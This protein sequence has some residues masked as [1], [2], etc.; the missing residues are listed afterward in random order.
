MSPGAANLLRTC[1]AAPP[2]ARLML[3]HEPPGVGYYDDHAPRMTAEAARA[4]GYEV[5]LRE[6]PPGLDDA[7]LEAF[8]ASLTGAD[9][10]LFFARVGDQLRFAPAGATPATMVYALDAAALDG[11]FGRSCQKG[12][13]ALK[14]MVDAAFDRAARVRVTCPRGTDYAGRI[15]EAGSPPT[16]TAI[17]RFPILVH[18]PVPS[19]G[20]AGRVVLSRFLVGTGSR[21]YEPYLMSLAEDVVATVQGERVVDLEGPLAAA[22]RAHVEGVAAR[23]GVD[24]WFVHSWHAGLHPACGLTG[25]AEDAPERWSGGAFGAPRILHFHTCGA[26]AP[27]EVSWTLLDATVTL[28]GVALWDQGRLRP[29]RLEGGAAWAARHPDL[30]ALFETPEQAVGL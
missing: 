22:A 28:D 8:A 18:R 20:F 2:G 19:A 7:A 27:G 26:Y 11:P 6:A 23:F 15:A 5:I 10:V 4:S 3:V 16:D 13:L 29:E 17:G 12:M 9:H 24:P 1:V 14:Q 21:F 25:R 30:A